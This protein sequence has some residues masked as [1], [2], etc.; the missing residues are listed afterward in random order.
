M[1]QLSREGFSA[2]VLTCSGAW[3]SGGPHTLPSMTPVNFPGDTRS[4]V[5]AFSRTTSLIMR[6]SLICAPLCH[7]AHRAL[8]E[9][10][11]P[12]E[13][14]LAPWCSTPQ[15]WVQRSSLMQTQPLSCSPPPQLLRGPQGHSGRRRKEKPLGEECGEEGEGEE[16]RQRRRFLRAPP[17]PSGCLTTPECKSTPLLQMSVSA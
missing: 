13:G 15:L 7:P 8:Q 10:R 16:G 2:S 9:A 4:W 14:L 11:P 5:E 6:A 1:L 12:P 3:G 17:G